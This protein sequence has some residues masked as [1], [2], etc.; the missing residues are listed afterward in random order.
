MRNTRELLAMGILFLVPLAS[1]AQDDVE[2][3]PKSFVKVD[4]VQGTD[5]SKYNTYAL[6]FSSKV[7]PDQK[8]TVEGVM[9]ATLQVKGLQKV[10]MD[11]NPSLIVVLKGGSRLIYT[12]DSNGNPVKKGTLIVELMDPKLKKA[13]WWGTAED[14]FS[15]DPNK[16][17][18]LL[19]KKVSKMFEKYPPPT[20]R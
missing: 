7:T 4:W 8:Q 18:H 11:A 13:V 17:L 16:A 3:Y 9:D 20:N 2:M 1:V 12:L 14:I 10:G 5:F 19:Q 6:E 15:D